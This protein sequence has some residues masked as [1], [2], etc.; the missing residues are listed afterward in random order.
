MLADTT[1]L[2]STLEEGNTGDVVLC[3]SVEEGEVGDVVFWR[4]LSEEAK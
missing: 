4:R 3:S 1:L 2:C